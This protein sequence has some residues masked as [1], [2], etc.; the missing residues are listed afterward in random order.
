MAFT[1]LFTTVTVI[2]LFLP[3]SKKVRGN[4]NI[5]G[6]SADFMCNVKTQESCIRENP[7]FNFNCNICSVIKEAEQKI[8]HI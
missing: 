8:I 2:K 7:D 1:L 3:Q 4:G 6:P 5:T